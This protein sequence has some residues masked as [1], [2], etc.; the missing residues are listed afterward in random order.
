MQSALTV[1]IVD[2]TGAGDTFAG[3]FLGTWLNQEPPEAALRFAVV[4]AS[5][6]ITA[7]GALGLRVT[8]QDLQRWSKDAPGDMRRAA[9][10]RA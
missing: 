10:R 3:V 4:A 8:A 5:H 2:T 1:P 9:R 6:S 7:A